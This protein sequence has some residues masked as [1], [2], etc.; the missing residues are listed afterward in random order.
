M[1]GVNCVFFDWQCCNTLPDP[2]SPN[3]PAAI[4]LMTC[5][6]TC[7]DMTLRSISSHGSSHSGEETQTMHDKTLS[8]GP[9]GGKPL[10][11]YMLYAATLAA[12]ACPKVYT[13]SNFAMSVGLAAMRKSPVGNS[14]VVCKQQ[15]Q[16]L[17]DLRH[18]LTAILKCISSAEWCRRRDHSDQPESGSP[19][20]ASILTCSAVLC[21]CIQARSQCWAQENRQASR[22]KSIYA[23]ISCR[24]C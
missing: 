19:I 8:S 16:A 6:P 21:V 15:Q 12:F 23:S 1:T 5:A 10:H 7:A 11:I 3:L 13:S 2:P 14:V 17:V 18:A 24:M 22:T 20:P 4:V 9:L